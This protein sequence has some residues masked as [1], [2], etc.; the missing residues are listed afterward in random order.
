MKSVYPLS[1][2]S[3]LRGGSLFSWMIILLGGH[4]IGRMVVYGIIYEHERIEE[5]Y[6]RNHTWP[7]LASEFIPLTSG[8]QRLYQR[9]FQQ[10]DLLTDDENAYN[11]YV[12]AVQSA[13]TIPNYTEF[14]WGLTRGP[15]HMWKK[16]NDFLQ[17]GLPTATEEE[18]EDAIDA[19]L[20]PLFI[21][22]PSDLKHEVLFSLQPILEAWV[23]GDQHLVPYSAYGLRVYR[24]TSKLYMHVD[25]V[26]TH[27]ISAIFHINHD[28]RSKPWPLVIE[29]FHGMTVEVILEAGDLIL[30]ESSKCMHG[31]PRRLDGKWYTSLFV[32]FAPSHL[33]ATIDKQIM[34][35]H[36]RIP[37]HWPIRVESTT[38]TDHVDAYEMIDTYCKEPTCPEE[39][40]GLNESVVVRGPAPGYGRVL[41]QY[42]KVIELDLPPE[43]EDMEK[44]LSD[45][46]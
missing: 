8:W 33:T 9:R 32:H 13:I 30:Y 36:Y 17:R 31:R 46:F 42:G 1:T 45:E 11:A 22:L 18:Y 10:V 20:R 44:S 27:V 29:D 43:R 39:W 26:Q 14:G 35:T 40:C 6:K 15:I 21:E 4:F 41:T 38:A 37:P 5:Y 7:P 3:V 25:E 2:S 12:N 16:V 24:N 34:D 23:G 19:D 28:E